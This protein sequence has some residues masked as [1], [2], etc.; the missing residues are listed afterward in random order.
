MYKIDTTMIGY[1]PNPQNRRNHGARWTPDDYDRL[2]HAWFHTDYSFDE[3]CN[4]MGRS[5]A[6]IIAKL[7]ERGYVKLNPNTMCYEGD[8]QSS[9]TTQTQTASTNETA[10]KEDT[11]MNANIETKTFINGIDASTLDDAA[12]FQRIAKLEQEIDK[13]RSIRAGSTKLVAA[14]NKLEGDVADLVRYVDAR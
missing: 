4:K 11:T 1:D 2:A 13:L 3:I 6:S 12:I 10:T 9:Q 14:I 8:R 7:Q 5:Y